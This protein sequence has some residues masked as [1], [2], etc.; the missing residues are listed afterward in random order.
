MAEAAERLFIALYLD[1]NVDERL[2][3]ALRR[4][5]YDVVT[6]REAGRKGAR[7]EEQLEY[8]AAKRTALLSHDVAD[9][10]RLHEKWRMEEAVHWGILL[11]REV[12]FR[13]LL[14]RVLKCLDRYSAEEIRNQL[15]FI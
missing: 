13:R 2:A 14:Q 1:E 9:F 8:A 10:A 12:E 11:T 7:D 4:Y 6:T 5:G 15:V 3:P